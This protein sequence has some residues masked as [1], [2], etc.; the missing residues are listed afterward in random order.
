MGEGL[1]DP[2]GGSG[3]RAPLLWSWRGLPAPGS[4]LSPGGGVPCPTWRGTLAFVGDRKWG[5]VHFFLHPN[6]GVLLVG[7][8]LHFLAGVVA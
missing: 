3:A 2:L 5:F 6:G 7:A 1:P 8:L 4:I